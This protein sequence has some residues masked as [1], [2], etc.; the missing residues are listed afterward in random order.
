MKIWSVLNFH[1]SIVVLFSDSVIPLMGA[2]QKHGYVCVSALT[3]SRS[4]QTKWWGP[5]EIFGD[6]VQLLG[7]VGLGSPGNCLLFSTALPQGPGHPQKQL[8]QA[9]R[10]CRWIIHN[11]QVFPQHDDNET[12]PWTSAENI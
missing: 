1:M 2:L 7:I 10:F 5:Q 9:A 4:I 6:V 11:D 3:S 12:L 8:L